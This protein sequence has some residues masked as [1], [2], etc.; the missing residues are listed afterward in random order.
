MPLAGGNLLLD[1][2]FRECLVG[3]VAIVFFAAGRKQ[4]GRSKDSEDDWHDDE[5]GIDVHGAG[6]LQN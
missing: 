3:R 6:S 1:G 4:N 2:L 5:W